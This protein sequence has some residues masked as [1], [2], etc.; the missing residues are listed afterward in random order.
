MKTALRIYLPE[1]GFYLIDM[2]VGSVASAGEFHAFE[3]GFLVE[4]KQMV[5]TL[6]EGLF[7]AFHDGVDRYEV[8]DFEK[9][10][11]EH[12]VVCLA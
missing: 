11:E 9:G 6:R 12:H 7:Q 2:Q 5:M 3:D 4:R 1:R 8:T 10:T